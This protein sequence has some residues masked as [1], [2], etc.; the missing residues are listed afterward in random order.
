MRLLNT[1]DY[2]AQGRLDTQT[3][4]YDDGTRVDTDWDQ[5]GIQ[6]RSTRSTTDSPQGAPTAQTTVYDDG[7]RDTVFF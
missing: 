1:L 5:T 3:V 7:H 6:A 2:D 4:W